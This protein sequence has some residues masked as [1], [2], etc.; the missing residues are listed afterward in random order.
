MGRI[1]KVAVL[2]KLEWD[3]DYLR[4]LIRQGKGIVICESVPEADAIVY[5]VE[6]FDQ[7]CEESIEGVR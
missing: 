1:L 4:S 6:L 2:M 7:I 5:D 3:E